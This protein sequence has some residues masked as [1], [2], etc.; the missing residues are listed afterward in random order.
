MPKQ[1]AATDAP[2]VD[3]TTTGEVVD[4]DTHAGVGYVRSAVGETYL[5]HCIEIADGSRD[6]AVGQRVEFATTVRF[7]RA[8]AARV[9]KL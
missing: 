6:I 7:G 1:Y 9:V 8:E 4:F 5:L 2:P 3:G